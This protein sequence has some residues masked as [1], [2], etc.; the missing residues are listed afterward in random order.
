MTAHAPA[1]AAVPVLHRETALQTSP[2]L[3]AR[4]GRSL[5]FKMESQQPCGSFKMRGLGHLMAVRAGQGQTRFVCSSGGNAGLA[6]AWCGRA[7][8][9][10]VTVVLPQT[11]TPA[12]RALLH[13]LGARVEVE[14]AV[15]DEADARARALCAQTGAAYVSPFD[16]PLIW[17]GHASLIDEAARQGPRPDAVV[18]SVGGGGL[19]IGVL[20]GMARQGWSDVPLI[21]AETEGA[22]SLAAAMAAGR[23][24]SVGRIDSVAKSLGSLIVAE[25]AWRWT[26]R[27]DVR[28]VLVSDAQAVKGCVDLADGLRVLVEPA[29][30]A[31]MAAVTAEPEALKGAGNVLVVVC[32]GAAVD[33]N[34]LAGWRAELGV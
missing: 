8:G 9:V 33:L 18:L 2:A 32:G 5:L 21:A 10:E 27:H 7:L 15:W 13:E 28:S 29:C 26:T 25:E 14:G 3:D 17:E 30:G 11:S 16:D 1:S 31:A 12:V 24:V 4:L 22:A 6:A 23:P 34:A 19:M 20:I